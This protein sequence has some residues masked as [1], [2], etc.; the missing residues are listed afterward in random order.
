M[1]MRWESQCNF[2]SDP[3]VNCGFWW[4][5]LIWVRNCLYWELP[6]LL[7]GARFN[8]F[9]SAVD[10]FES[11]TSCSWSAFILLGEMTFFCSFWRW[12]LRYYVLLEALVGNTMGWTTPNLHLRSNE[13]KNYKI[14]VLGLDKLLRLSIQCTAF[15]IL[16]PY[17]HV[18]VAS[19]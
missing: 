2:W 6:R 14:R 17:C 5:L 11:A 10:S 8:S 1:A 7:L 9:G 16:D 4:Q 15:N 3:V 13:S 18:S 19:F 12:E